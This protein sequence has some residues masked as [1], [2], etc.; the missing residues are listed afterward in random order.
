MT[1]IDAN[2][3]PF[4]IFHGDKDPLVLFCENEMLFKALQDAKVPRRYYLVPNAQHGPG[5][6]LDKYFGMMNS[7][8]NMEYNTSIREKTIR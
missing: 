2:D 5:L 4:L 7:F 3:P 8:F 6:F 1:Y